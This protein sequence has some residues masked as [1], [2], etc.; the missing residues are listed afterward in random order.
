MDQY[1]EGESLFL[2]EST[3]GDR[4]GMKNT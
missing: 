3:G 4:E 1:L 2:E